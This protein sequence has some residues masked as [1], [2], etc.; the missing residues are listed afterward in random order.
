MS[1]E[2]N[3]QETD[4]PASEWSDLL[5]DDIDFD[6]VEKQ[7]RQIEKYRKALGKIARWFDEFPATGQFWDEEKTNPMSYGACFG[8][9]GERD[10]MR[11]IA[12]DALKT[13]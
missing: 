12:T 3:K 8:S 1:N 10:F 2:N 13:V 5:D 9:N 11:K 4:A 6:I 7:Q